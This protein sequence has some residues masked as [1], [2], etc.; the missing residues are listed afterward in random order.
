MEDHGNVIGISVSGS[1]TAL[2]SDNVG[3]MVGEWDSKYIPP[4]FAGLVNSAIVC[5]KN[6]VGG[7]VGHLSRGIAPDMQL[8][9]ITNKGD[10][11]G[12]GDNVGG[13]FGYLWIY[14]DVYIDGLQNFGKIE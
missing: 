13:V 9:K 10:V 1:V 3:G 5:G 8:E 6:N 4:S 2:S 11:K 14:A 7:V 12:S